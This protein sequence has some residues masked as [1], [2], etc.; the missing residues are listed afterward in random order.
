MTSTATLA[1]T[2]HLGGA[3]AAEVAALMASVPVPPSVLNAFG[4]RI[5]SDST[6]VASPVVRTIVLGLNPAST[7]TAT[8]TLLD[9]GASGSSVGALAVTSPGSGYVLPPI[10]TF[11][12]GRPADVVRPGFPT[13]S[14]DVN[15]LVGS[16]NAPAVA[17]AYL[18]AVSVSI[19][20][21]GT[22]YSAATTLVVT[23]RQSQDGTPMVLTP[24]IAGGVITGVAITDPGS[25]YTGVP[26]ITAV[27][28]GTVPGSGADITVTM[29]VGK[30]ELY[31]GGAGY[32]SVPTVVLTP[33]F[34]AFFPSTSDQARPLE[35]LMT[36]ALEAATMGPVFASPVMIA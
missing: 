15:P 35:Q 12:G 23:G 21:G 18:E 13:I 20:S 28:P 36:S 4:L 7:A 22:G 10:V 34:Q 30:L 25:G 1:Y 24:T 6:P 11:T 19:P 5:L 16:V 17:Q 9:H 27:D 29:G 2:A 31:R 33:V 32:S 8:A 3:T 26:S 14:I